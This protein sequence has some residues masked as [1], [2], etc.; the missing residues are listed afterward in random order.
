MKVKSVAVLAALT[1]GIFVTGLHATDATPAPAKGTDYKYINDAAPP[2]KSTKDYTFMDVT[3]PEV[4]PIANYGFQTIE[5][6]G[7]ALVTEVTHELATKDTAAAVSILHLKDLQLPKPVPGRPTVT[8]IKRTSLLV[9]NPKNA[10]DVA[11]AAALEYIH[12]QLVGGDLPDKMLVQKISHPGEPV[13][14]R[15]Y[16][17]IGA[18]QSCLACHGDPETFRPGVKAAL[19]QLYPE[20]K[21]V[22]YM[23]HEWRGVIRVSLTAPA[24]ATK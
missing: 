14:W 9:R 3:D 19:D 2:A 5:S 13:E 15:V 24:P 11:D 18:S 7:A 6:V 17:P 8:A 20:D 10:P 12:A 16:R 4:A 21:A 23:Q 1:G 22:N